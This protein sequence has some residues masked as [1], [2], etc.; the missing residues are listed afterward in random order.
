MI[1]QSWIW[2]TSIFPTM[3]FIEIIEPI[4][5]IFHGIILLQAKKETYVKK[6]WSYKCS[7]DWS[8]FQQQVLKTNE[9]IYTFKWTKNVFTSIRRINKNSRSDLKPFNF[10]LHS[11]FFSYKP[12]SI[13]GLNSDVYMNIHS[14]IS[15][16]QAIVLQTLEIKSPGKRFHLCIQK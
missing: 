16:Y 8:R 15:T 11:L 10:C 4:F 13:F 3:G 14:Y 5:Q 12:I 7:G 6:Q 9:H 1:F 2:N